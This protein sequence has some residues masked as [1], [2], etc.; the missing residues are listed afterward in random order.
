MRVVDVFSLTGII[1]MFLYFR[2]LHFFSKNN[3][4]AITSKTNWN[5]DD[6]YQNNNGVHSTLNSSPTSGVS[7]YHR[8][9]MM[10]HTLGDDFIK[11][12]NNFITNS[13]LVRDTLFINNYSQYTIFIVRILIHK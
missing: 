6:G 7:Y 12:P 13:F 9:R 5:L 1:T 3:S 4:Y 8:L 11:C 2:Y 10:L